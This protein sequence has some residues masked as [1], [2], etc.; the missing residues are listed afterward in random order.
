PPPLALRR[1]GEELGTIDPA[2]RKS[3][4]WR[5]RTVSNALGL[6]IPE[7]KKAEL[8]PY[9]CRDRPSGKKRPRGRE[10]TPMGSNY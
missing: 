1:G 9:G 2:D 6:K 4:F 10:M 5:S 8:L 7:N 3:C